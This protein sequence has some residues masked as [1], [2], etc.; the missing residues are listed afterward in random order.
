MNDLLDSNVAARIRAECR[1]A[2]ELHRF[3]RAVFV[4]ETILE[5]LAFPKTVKVV[6]ELRVACGMIPGSMHEAP[7][8]P[9]PP[10]VATRFERLFPEIAPDPQQVKPRRRRAKA[11]DQLEQAEPGRESA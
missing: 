8:V 10:E 3:Q 6:R 1:D 2:T 9:E 7:Q 11:G 5:S 4:I